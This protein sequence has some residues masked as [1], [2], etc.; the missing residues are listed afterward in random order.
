[1]I[2]DFK[3]GHYQRAM[4]IAQPELSRAFRVKAKGQRQEEDAL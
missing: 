3:L 1:M 2:A 4:V